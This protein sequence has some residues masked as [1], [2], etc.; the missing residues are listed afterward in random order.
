MKI[1]KRNQLIILVI[2][3]MLITSGYLNFTA[4][5][6]NITTETVAD[7]S[8]EKIGDAEF[9]STIPKEDE[10][11][12]IAE[13]LSDHNITQDTVN[14][15]SNKNNQTKTTK[16]NETEDYYFTTSKLESV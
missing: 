9:V 12:V 14:N 15:E 16:A 11:N 6:K 13:A 3:L 5:H 10:E 2:S 1:L 7:R 8:D 4:N